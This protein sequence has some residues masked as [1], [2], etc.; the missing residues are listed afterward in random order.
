MVSGWII[1]YTR[2]LK[3][4]LN[5]RNKLIDFATIESAKDGLDLP[6]LERQIATQATIADVEVVN[7]YQLFLQ[8]KEASQKIENIITTE[9]KNVV[10]PKL[11]VEPPEVF[12]TLMTELERITRG[13]VPDWPSPEPP[14][15]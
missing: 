3:A 10:G 4:I 5:D 6:A 8:L 12:G 7:A 1:T 15:I 14:A 9:Y 2:Y 13:V 11:K